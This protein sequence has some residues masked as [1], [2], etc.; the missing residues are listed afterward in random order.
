MSLQTI[1]GEKRKE[2]DKKFDE[3]KVS[4]K[5]IPRLSDSETRSSFTEKDVKSF[6]FSDLIPAFLEDLKEDISSMKEQDSSLT[7][8]FCYD[9][10]HLTKSYNKAIEKVVNL[11]SESLSDIKK[12]K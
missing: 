6:I 4:E 11:F 9:Q 5:W 12:T 8:D 2:F 7:D 3:F 1:I 10:H